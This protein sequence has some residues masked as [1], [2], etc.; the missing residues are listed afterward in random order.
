MR[1]IRGKLRGMFENNRPGGKAILQQDTGQRQAIAAIIAHTADNQYRPA[2]VVIAG[3][4]SWRR[5]WP[6]APSGQQR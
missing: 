4:A 1:C 3:A 2:A 5:H 6:R